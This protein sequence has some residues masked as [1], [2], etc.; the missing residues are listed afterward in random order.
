MLKRKR[1][2]SQYDK[3]RKEATLTKLRQG[4]SLLK[5]GKYKN[6]PISIYALSKQTGIARQTIAKYTEIR[7]L[8]EKENNPGVPLKT[9]VVDVNK[10]YTLEQAVSIID[11]ITK[12]YNEAKDKYNACLK[13]LADA[14]LKATRLMVEKKELELVIERYE[15][16]SDLHKNGSD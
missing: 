1:T 16:N 10:V 5:Q 13:A 12:A 14:N 3:A 6:R 7:D 9:A 8:I 2:P 11:A 4:I 15:K